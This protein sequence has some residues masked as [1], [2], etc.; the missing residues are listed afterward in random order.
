MLH[1]GWGM[2]KKFTVLVSVVVLAVALSACGKSESSES[3]GAKTKN[4]AL[5][6]KAAGRITIT[7]QRGGAT[8]VSCSYEAGAATSCVLPPLRGD[9]WKFGAS[10]SV[11]GGNRSPET[12]NA[13]SNTA[14]RAPTTVPPSTA[15]PA[16][17]TVPPT[18][19]TTIWWSDGHLNWG[20]REARCAEKRELDRTRG[21]TTTS[22]N[23]AYQDLAGRNFRGANL[24]GANL[25]GAILVG[26][27]LTEADLFGANLQGANLTA[28]NLTNTSVYCANFF[29]ATLDNANLDNT[30]FWWTNLGM[31]NIFRA[32]AN[33][34][35]F[36]GVNLTDARLNESDLG[37][38]DFLP[39]NV[40]TRA[41]V[42]GMVFP[43]EWTQD[44]CQRTGAQ[45]CDLATKRQDPSLPYAPWRP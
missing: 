25:Q 10:L 40:W 34:T 33:G 37:Y 21:L 28:A 8:S 31:A 29:G 19:T 14:S 11:V 3:G 23:Y 15:S 42:R 30:Y 32:N 44:M 22:L 45:Q 4:S 36:G 24:R 1:Y 26:A 6:G 39:G 35:D 17:T 2:Q 12:T 9:G 7:A 5:A 43:R 41:N 27:N 38:A 20:N 16:P 13:P 18:T